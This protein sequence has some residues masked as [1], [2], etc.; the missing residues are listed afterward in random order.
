MLSIAENELL[1]RVG[2]NTPT[3]ELMRRYWHPVCGIDDLQRSPFRTKEIKLLGEELVVYCDRSGT[4]GVVAKYCPH[5]RASI[6]SSRSVAAAARKMASAQVS[7]ENKNRLSQSE[8]PSS[9]ATRSG[10]KKIRSSVSR[11]G[12]FILCSQ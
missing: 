2:P 8:S 12:P 11:L 9:V 10:T 3:G 6:P 5:R 4:L 7:R 1:T